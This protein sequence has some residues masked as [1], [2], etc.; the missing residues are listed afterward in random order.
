MIL[1]KASFIVGAA[2]SSQQFDQFD[3]SFLQKKDRFQLSS[4]FVGIKFFDDRYELI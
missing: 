4:R 3:Y 1:K 2:G